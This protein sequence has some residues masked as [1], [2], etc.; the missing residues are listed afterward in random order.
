MAIS[1][2]VRRPTWARAGTRSLGRADLAV[3]GF[4]ALG[5]GNVFARRGSGNRVVPASPPTFI[6]GVVLVLLAAVFCYMAMG[7][8]ATLPGALLCTLAIAAQTCLQPA[9]LLPAPEVYGVGLAIAV[10]PLVRVSRIAWPLIGAVAI[11]NASA[12]AAV[13]T[14]GSAPID[15]FQEVQGATSAL[16]NGH[17]PYTPVFSVFLDQQNGHVLYGSGSFC[18]GP[19]IVLLSIPSRLLGDVRLT[20]VALN[21]AILVAVLVWARRAG[22]SGRMTRLITALWVASP[23]V[24]FMVLSEWTDSFCV[25]GLAWWLVLRE[26]HRSWATAALTIGLASKPSVLLVMVPLVFWMRDVRREVIWAAAATAVI[27]APFALWTGLPQFVYDTVGVFADLPIRHDGLTVDGVASILGHAFV[28][29]A[30]LVVGIAAAVALFTLRR[31]RDYGSLLAAGAGLLIAVCLF[32]KQAFLNYYYIGGMALL[33]TIG[34]GT[35]AP[36]EPLVS[37][38]DTGMSALRRRVPSFPAQR[39]AAQRTARSEAE[40]T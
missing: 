34:A 40:A 13:W 30:L 32:G 39:P 37:L 3:L 7:R 38:L 10:V 4:C 27:V 18:Y 28:P 36:R 35:L 1:S 23:F 15:V 8:P 2:L 29:G 17:N 31:P 14:W 19:M 5:A 9:F 25:A 11:I 22:H 20:V 33:F 16:I 21:L 26:R 12:V 6:F 24:P